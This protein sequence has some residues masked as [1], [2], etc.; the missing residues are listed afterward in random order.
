MVIP[1]ARVYV[2][3][4]LRSGRDLAQRVGVVKCPISSDEFP[5]KAG[6]LMGMP[7]PIIKFGFKVD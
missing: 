6:C 2:R 1:F 7:N 3:L 4:A 5:P